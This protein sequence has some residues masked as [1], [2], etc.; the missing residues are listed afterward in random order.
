MLYLQTLGL[1]II[2]VTKDGNGRDGFSVAYFMCKDLWSCRAFEQ[3]GYIHI[4]NIF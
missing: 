1:W 4:F 2:Y 3:K